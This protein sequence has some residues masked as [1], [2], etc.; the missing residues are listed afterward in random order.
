MIADHLT[1]LDQFDDDLRTIADDFRAN[2]GLASNEYFMPIM[3]LLFLRHATN[4]F[5]RAKTAIDAYKAVGRM[6]GRPLVDGDFT[7]R[8]ALNLPV[9][10]RFDRVL[11]AP[12]DGQ[13]GA[14]LTAATEA[15]EEKFDP[16]KGQLPKDYERF[17]DDLLERLRAAVG[18]GFGRIYEYFLAEFSKEGA[19]D[20][21]E[22]FTPP[23]IVLTIVPD[24]RQCHRA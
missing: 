17:D 4:R 8:R 13:L 15:V 1:N 22:F 12:K 9:A 5:H 7:K 14:A 19:H 11:E 16:L 3:G 2:S 24:N 18:D 6:P 21:G 10:A 20:N 23:S